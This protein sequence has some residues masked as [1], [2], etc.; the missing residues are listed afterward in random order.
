VAQPG[1]VT[2]VMMIRLICTICFI[3]FSILCF[4]IQRRTSLSARKR[5]KVQ[6]LVGQF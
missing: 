2:M 3:C 1:I 6:V 5:R 4:S